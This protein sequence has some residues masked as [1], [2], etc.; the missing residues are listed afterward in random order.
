MPEAAENINDELEQAVVEI[1]AAT[2]ETAEEAPLAGDE[3]AEAPAGETGQQ[4]EAPDPTAE[5]FA[6]W[7]ESDPESAQA[8]LDWRES[9]AEAAK[10]P[11]AVIPMSDEDESEIIAQKEI[12]FTKTVMET[13]RNIARLNQEWS[14]DAQLYNQRK[15]EADRI[16]EQVNLGEVPPTML[17]YARQL[18]NLEAQKLQTW[19]QRSDA[20]QTDMEV[21]Q[22]IGL[23]A[24][25]YKPLQR[26]IDD[27][28]ALHRVNPATGQSLVDY[29][30]PFKTKM[31]ILET[32]LNRRGQSLSGRKTVAGMQGK[33]SP[34]QVQRML[35]AYKKV[36]VKIGGKGGGVNRARAVANAGT[37]QKTTPKAL[38]G[39]GT[40]TP[41][42][43]EI[44][45][46]KG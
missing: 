12:D 43:L 7:A 45:K 16:E 5:A 33:K 4:A 42:Q 2:V 20:L 29:R 35:D 30:L 1:E 44:L 25:K 9:Q 27:Y 37:A 41:R 24:G 39:L 38:E 22:L 40:M 14:R 34:E 31:Q 23:E 36:A 32:E 28:I 10:A 6:K 17:Q 11:A 15:A 26:H 21:L 18:E 46:R 13:Q 3:L 19:K 8:Y